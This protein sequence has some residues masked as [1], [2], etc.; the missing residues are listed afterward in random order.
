MA[1]QRRRAFLAAV[2]AAGVAGCRTTE[3]TSSRTATESESATTTS[4]PTPTEPARIDSEWPMPAHDAG[5]TSATTAAGPAVAV[6]RLWTVEMNTTPFQPILVDG[7]LYT[8][9]TDGTLT[10]LDART[11]DEQWTVSTDATATGTPW[12]A[13][14]QLYVP[15]EEDIAAF[16]SDGTAQWQTATPDR[17]GLIATADGL[18]YAVDADPPAVVALDTDG[19]QRWQ[20][21]IDDPWR[22]RL[23][24]TAE[25]VLVSSGTH[26]SRYWT[27]DATSGDILGP[28]PRFGHDFP[29]ELC[30]RHG[31]MY[32]VDPFFGG[33]DA[34]SATDAGH[35]WN[36]GAPGGGEPTMSVTAET[37]YYGV[38]SPDSPMVL[39]FDSATGTERWRQ[40]LDGDIDGLMVAGT[41]GAFVPTT[42]G[43]VC[44]A[45]D[46]GTR[47]WSDS[48][49]TAPLTIADD[50]LFTATNEGMQAFRAR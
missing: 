4:V 28:E 23:F 41:A 19:T 10:A 24:A 16:T 9:T 38:N 37:L 20:T 3:P 35:S 32:A 30:Y 48:D 8:V 33:L 6:G 17:A 42:E 21:E 18:Y 44:L 34:I 43:T 49:L 11:G 50:V 36:A 25:R 22:P 26:D 12:Y 27:L 31:T 2:A 14:D 7:V 15:R 29:T 13:G 47:R 46:D 40:P 45:E 39:A 5:L 1:A